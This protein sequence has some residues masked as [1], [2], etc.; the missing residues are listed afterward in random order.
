MLCAVTHASFQPPQEYQNF[1][2]HTRSQFLVGMLQMENGC[3]Q[4]FTV[5]LFVIVGT[6]VPCAT[7]V[8]FFFKGPP[9]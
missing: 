2:A 9:H 1:G 3:A 8:D 7:A 5:W 4:L 6:L